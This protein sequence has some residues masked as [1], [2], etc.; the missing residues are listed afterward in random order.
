ML[1]HASGNA[2]TGWLTALLKDSGLP[3][4]HQGLAG[5]L[6]ATGWINVI[7]YGVAALLLIVLTRGRLGYAPSDVSPAADKQTP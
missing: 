2:A 7:A 1:F 3:V 4:P 5:F 6:A